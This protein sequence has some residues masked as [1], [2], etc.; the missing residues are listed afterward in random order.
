MNGYTNVTLLQQ[1][2]WSEKAELKMSKSFRDGR[3]WS[4]SLEKSDDKESDNINCVSI[5]SLFEEHH[6]DYIDAL[7]IDIEGA[8]KE[9]FNGLLKDTSILNRIRFIAVEIHDE[10]A[11]RQQISNILLN[12]GFE[13]IES[14]ETTLAYN[15]NLIA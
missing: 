13:V 6:L 4:F 3:E 7:K 5:Q 14:N 11:D 9:V 10:V 1:G 12:N 15:K 2:L 8:E